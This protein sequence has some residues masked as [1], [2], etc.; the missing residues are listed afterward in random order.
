[1]LKKI[2]VA[3]LELGMHIHSFEGSW[4]NHPFWHAAFVLVNPIDLDR[5]RCSEA[6]YCWIDESLGVVAKEAGVE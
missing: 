3:Q 4:V 5:A 6:T 2:P 1:M